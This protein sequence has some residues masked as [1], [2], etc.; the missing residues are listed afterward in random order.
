MDNIMKYKDYWAEIKY[1]DED[2]CFCGKVSGLKKDVILFEGN[3]VEDLKKDFEEAIDNYLE[4]CKFRK[5]KPEKQCKGSFNVRIKPETHKQ[6]IIIAKQ[7]NISLNQFVE[8]AISM[9]VSNCINS[10]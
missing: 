1:S 5:E 7:K 10:K 8:N 2:R 3:T 6:A 4:L 9:Y